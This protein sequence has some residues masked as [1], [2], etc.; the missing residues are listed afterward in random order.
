MPLRHVSAAIVF[1]C[2]L[3]S[4]KAYASGPE[5]ERCASAAEEG[6]RQRDT[7]H[8]LAA[9]RS[10]LVCAAEGCPSI[11]Q[12]DCTAWIADLDRTTP[13]IVVRAHDAH[14][15]DITDVRVV[16]DGTPLVEQL[17]GSAVAVDPG[18]HS[19]RYETRSSV[20]EERILVA[21]GEKNR[22]LAVEIPDPPGAVP[23]ASR[24]EAESRP[25]SV[26]SVRPPTLAFVLGGVSLLALGSFAFF[27]LRG[28]ADYR[29]LRDSCAPTHS[30][31]E[32]DVDDVR[33]KFV[34]AGLSLG[35]GVLALAAATWLTLSTRSGATPRAVG[36]TF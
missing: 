29:Q 9:R 16:M 35:A 26:A 3:A 34:A 31:L 25:G 10:F 8:L 32:S 1:S 33:T 28:Q 21:I 30:C 6:Q 14:G 2:C 4:G 11:V 13:S 15:R 27:E 19:I 5:A 23:S 17:D 24:P 20:R 22:V 12:K 7:R 18:P 36:A